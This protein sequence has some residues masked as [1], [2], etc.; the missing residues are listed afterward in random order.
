MLLTELLLTQKGTTKGEVYSIYAPEAECIA[1]G[2]A[3]KPY[4]FGVKVEMRWVT[5]LN[6][7]ALLPEKQLWNCGLSWRP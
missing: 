6:S 4:E 3:D 1:K 5:S 7:V 2:K